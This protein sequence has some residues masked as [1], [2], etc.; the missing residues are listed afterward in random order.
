MNRILSE[1]MLTNCADSKISQCSRFEQ[2][3]LLIGL[4]LTAKFKPNLMCIDSPTCGLDI[5]AAQQVYLIINQF[6][7]LFCLNSYCFLFLDDKLPFESL[8][9]LFNCNISKHSPTKQ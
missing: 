9:K 1:L 2:K 4:E 8:E 6:E 3:R 7:F 5:Y